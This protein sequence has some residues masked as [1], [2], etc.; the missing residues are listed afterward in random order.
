MMSAEVTKI[1]GEALLFGPRRVV[2]NAHGEAVA[3]RHDEPY[4]IIF[5]RHD[6]WS[7]GAPRELAAI[8]EGMWADCWVAV[9]ARDGVPV[10]YEAWK[11]RRARLLNAVSPA[12]FCCATLKTGKVKES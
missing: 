11:A 1:C 9:M 5:I 4:D 3:P 10:D 6:G 7:L 8:A 2:I 12:G